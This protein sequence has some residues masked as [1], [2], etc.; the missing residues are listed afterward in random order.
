MWKTF[1]SIIQYAHRFFTGPTFSR[2]VPYRTE[3]L[4]NRIFFWLNDLFLTYRYNMVRYGTLKVRFVKM[5]MRVLYWVQIQMEHLVNIQCV[6]RSIL[7]S[8]QAGHSIQISVFF[9]FLAKKNS[10]ANVTFLFSYLLYIHTSTLINI[11]AYH[12]IYT[13]MYGITLV[14]YE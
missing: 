7:I 11:N 14:Y 10:N 13:Y 6:L 5:P 1:T 8:T 2:T 12:H 4:E 9:P 3:I